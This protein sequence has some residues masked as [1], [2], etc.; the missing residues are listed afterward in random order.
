MKPREGKKPRAG[1]ARRRLV[2]RR[3]ECKTVL[4][5]STI[6]QYTM[7]CYTG[8]QHSCIYC[9]ARFMQ[10]FHPHPEPWG[11]FVD[12]KVNAPEALARQLKRAKP[13]PVFVSSATDAWQ[14]L[15]RKWELTRECCRMLIEHGFRVNALTKNTLILRDLDIFRPGLTQVGVTITTLDRRLAKLWEPAA[16]SVEER[17]HVLQTASDAGLETAIMFGP[18]LPALSDGQDSLNA[19]FERAAELDVDLIWVDAMNPR[20][21]V[22]PSVGPFL[23]R[24]F[25]DLHDHYSRLLHHGETRDAYVK[26]LGDRVRK[27]ARQH[28]VEGRLAGC[29]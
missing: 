11:E 21:R 27:A 8:C 12:V 13:G 26:E 20:P 3:V 14:P 5:R 17:C 2:V 24:E 4:N 23:R 15:E 9:Y 29:P 1:R 25:P 28:H 6:G 18:L 10:R 16:S 19:L 22:W 7:N